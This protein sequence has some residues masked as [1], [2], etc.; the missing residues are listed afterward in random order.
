[1]S[2]SISL[3]PT[4]S[5]ACIHGVLHPCTCVTAQ[6]ATHR[7]SLSFWAATVC[8]AGDGSRQAGT[9]LSCFG[10]HTAVLPVITS[11]GPNSTTLSP[12]MH[13]SLTRLNC[14]SMGLHCHGA[15]ADLCLINTRAL[16]LS[17]YGQH[18]LHSDI[19][20]SHQLPHPQRL[21]HCRQVLT[22]DMYSGCSIDFAT[23]VCIFESHRAGHSFIIIVIPDV[24]RLVSKFPALSASNQAYRISYGCV[25]MR[26]D[27]C[28][29]SI[30][31]RIKLV[32]EHCHATCIRESTCKRL[33]EILMCIIKVRSNLY[34][35]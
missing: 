24:L 13:R 31:N 28:M 2:L 8:A 23:I 33:Q 1:M 9:A 18:V 3:S 16:S 19:S 35:A 34:Q 27:Q 7:L 12:R 14:T 10:S 32:L 17:Q 22:A 30:A 25:L 29:P 26:G 21:L 15:P 11:G 4:T 5:H 6:S 20:L